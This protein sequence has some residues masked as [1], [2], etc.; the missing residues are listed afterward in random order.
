MFG[1]SGQP[2]AGN[3]YV[4]VVASGG[5]D[6]YGNTYATGLNALSGNLQGVTLVGSAMDATSTLN[7]TQLQQATVLNP[8]ISGGTATSLVHTIT[9]T[10]GA[11]LGYTA[12]ATTTTFSTAGLY[13]W[14]CPTGITNVQVQCWG[15]G[16]GGDG[17]NSSQGGAGGGGG[18]YAAE[19]NFAVIPGNVYTVVVGI[20]GIGGFSE[21]SSSGVSS[22]S[23]G[24][25]STFYNSNGQSQGVV[26]NGGL[27]GGAFI[28]GEGG[29]GSGNTIHFDGGDGANGSGF[30][31]GGGGGGS[32]GP[33]VTGL[34]AE[35]NG[36]T[37]SAGNTGGA[38]GAAVT[39]GAAGGAGGNS[40]T[41]GT[42]GASPGG[43]GGGA[44]DDGTETFTANFTPNGGTQSY[45]G[46]NATGYNPNSLENH[47]GLMYQGQPYVDSPP[48]Y[49]YSIMTL[50]YASIEATLSGKTVSQV[51]LY[52]SCLHTY[53]PQAG[54]IQIGYTSQ[55]AFGTTLDYPPPGYTAVQISG[56]VPGVNTINLGLN[57]GIGVA[58]GNG[59]C[60]A[61]VI[62]DGAISP[63]QEYYAYFDSGAGGGYVPNITVY[64]SDGGSATAGNGGSG[65]VSI[66]YNSSTPAY[67]LSVSAAA[68]TDTYGNPYQAGLTGQQVTV[69]GTQAPAFDP[70]VLNTVAS[71]AVL[72]ANNAGNIIVNNAQGFTGQ[73]PS[74]QSDITKYTVTTTTA[75]AVTNAYPIPALDPQVGTVYRLTAWGDVVN[76]TT[77]QTITWSL[78]GWG[79]TLATATW[80]QAP[81]ATSVTYEWVVTAIAQISGT[82]ASGSVRTWLTGT[83]GLFNSN[84]GNIGSTSYGGAL[85]GALGDTAISTVAGATLGFQGK[86]GGA[87]PSMHG[88]GSMLE[89]LGP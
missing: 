17:G 86:F 35:G 41:N 83:L 70:P 29:F 26:A 11:V 59:N 81:Q 16:G 46:G 45:Y 5:V 74:S 37:A 57:G 2:G 25:A 38:G 9:N 75:V 32:A 65:Q 67:T 4:A 39:G 24:G 69:L 66:T 28:G 78:V 44:G 68:F 62:G 58:L 56:V 64:Y 47:D 51:V 88:N 82:G 63:W 73:V 77:A 54:E 31:G 7:G 23:Q 14:T 61:L 84:L 55:G 22:G 33:G 79:L 30:N 48:G 15:A 43:G 18:E 3:L 19:P 6:A 21:G 52:I 20:P 36:G 60:K 50:P 76:T 87:G 27:G 80:G 8:G 12:G 53:Y 85:T 42:A 13:L 1:Y 72:G 34:G 49:Q 71:A 10:G 40:L 89:R